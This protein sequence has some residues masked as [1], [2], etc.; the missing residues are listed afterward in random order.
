MDCSD[1]WNER[2]SEPLYS[3]YSQSDA[4]ASVPIFR[5]L[6]GLH[7]H[8]RSQAVLVSY[9]FGVVESALGIDY[10]LHLELELPLIG[11]ISSFEIPTG[12]WRWGLVR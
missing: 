4:P 2:S 8:R 9:C 10:S 3:Q 7:L 11:S 6:G 12:R 5:L 1:R